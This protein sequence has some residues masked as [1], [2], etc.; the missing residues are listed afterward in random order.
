MAVGLLCRC[1]NRFQFIFQ[2]RNNAVLQF[3]G[4]FVA[5]FPLG[6]FSLNAGLIKL[7][8]QFGNIG[9]PLFFLFPF[10]IEV[11]GFNF[12]PGNFITDLLQPC[13]GSLVGF[14]FQRFAFNLQLQNA[15]VKLVQFFRL[16]ID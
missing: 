6:N 15:T 9:Q 2:F 14:F 10:I 11:F 8:F 12:Q 3:A 4:T 5:P 13:F 1:F 7:V 16:G